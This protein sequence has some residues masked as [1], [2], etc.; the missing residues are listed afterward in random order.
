MGR[1]QFYL[2]YAL[3]NLTRNRRW[4]AFALLSVAAG[5][6]TV[7]ALRSLGLAIGDSLTS[8]I[9]ATNKGDIAI[10]RN[11]GPGGFNFGRTSRDN[12]F[13]I[14]QLELIRGWV[15][16]NDSLHTE[17]SATNLQIS[18]AEERAVGIN[19]MTGIFIDPATYPPTTTIRTVE[20]DGVPIADLL[21]GGREV[22]VSSNLAEA[23]NFRVG[24]RVRV[25]GSSETFTIVGIV[26][27]EQEAGLRDIFA[28]FFGFAY[29]HIDQAE[30]VNLDSRPNRIS[31]L[32]PEGTSLERIRRSGEELYDLL[33]GEDGFTRILT[34]ATILEQNETVSDIIERFIVVMGLGAML[35][36]GVGIINTML[37]MVR[38]RTDE[39]AALKTFGLKGRQVAL[40]FMTE[41]L[42]LGAVGSFIG[43]LVGAGLSLL[44]NAYGERLI[45][46]SVPMRIY[47]EA[48]VFGV[49]LG[50]VVTAVFGVMPVLTAVKVRPGI[51]LRPN[52]GYVPAL[53]ILQSVGVVIFVVLALGIIAGQIIGPFP[54]SI[55]TFSQL[56][57]PQNITA[58]ILLVAVT[59]SVLGVLVVVLWG[60]VWLVGRIPAFGWIDLNLSLRNLGTR[61]LRTA[62]TLLAISTGIF[63]ISAISFYGAGVREILQVSLNDSLGGNILILSPSSFSLDV[64]GNFR[65]SQRQLN[66]ALDE[67]GETVVHR[68]RFMNY[69]GRMSMV[70]SL[71]LRDL[72]ADVDR[73]VL[74]RELNQASR[75]G[76]FERANVISEQLEALVT[77]LNVVMVDTDNPNLD[78]GNVIAGRALTAEDR[79]SRR[80]VVLYEGRMADWG[81]QVG[82][83]IIVQVQGREYV[84]DVVGLIGDESEFQPN[85]PGDMIIPFGALGSVR[86]NF[87]FNTV[88]VAPDDVN[89][90]EQAIT[91]MPFFFTVNVT[92]IDGVVSQLITQ[93]SALPILVSLLSL[94]AAAVIMANTV[95]L[96]TFE[97]RRQIGILKAVGLKRRRVVTIMLLENLIISLLGAVLGIGAS[98]AG[99]ALLAAIGLDE[100]VFIPSDSR[101]VVVGLVVASLL[102]GI[103]A[104]LL[105]VNGAVRERVTNVL[106]YE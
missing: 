82:S 40:L 96:A 104:T 1:L 5:V 78:L 24:Q 75:S 58:G 84:F 88:Q 89:T 85:A 43:S 77:P 20:P 103:V 62:T 60:V 41:A 27:S 2:Q 42:L 56:P 47:P 81:V 92:V 68:T 10:A 102:I 80:A 53:G 93:F 14:L 3:R 65:D 67:L 95:A 73:E 54:E 22:I 19:F 35:I 59:L 70:D 34:V 49:V 76:D 29:F 31:I 16:R 55:R 72:E 30:T 57:L 66:R 71:S 23:Q 64:G 99:I 33:N 39:I 36:G 69:D 9:Q 15:D 26:P 17:Y 86:P 50:F 105:S 13:N 8:N 83:D 7:V 74:F 32:L 6:A 106:R 90:V 18:P 46:Q 94:G 38:R 48:I 25:T 51:I 97:R 63:A 4:S 28:A 98:A 52:E 100:L 61:R 101:P 87:Q 11:S 45:L 37:V 91:Q 12:A 44:T 79:G 21:T